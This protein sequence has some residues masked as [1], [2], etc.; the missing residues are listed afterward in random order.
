MIELEKYY[1]SKGRKIKLV[2]SWCNEHY[3]HYVIAETGNSKYLV[4]TCISD[5]NITSYVIK[6]EGSIIHEIALLNNFKYAIII[7]HWL[8]GPIIMLSNEKAYEL[9]KEVFKILGYKLLIEE[10]KNCSK[11]A[12]FELS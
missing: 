6:S 1:V 4:S 5:G 9:M 11:I 3:V 7:D 2:Y 10:V 8:E 12:I